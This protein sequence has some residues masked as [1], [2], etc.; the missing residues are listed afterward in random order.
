LQYTQ[1]HI[2]FVMGHIIV[3][4]FIIWIIYVR[5]WGEYVSS[6]SV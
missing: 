5:I 6:S 4:V 3:L 2:I 1:E